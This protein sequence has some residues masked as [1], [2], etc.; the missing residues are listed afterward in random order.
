MRPVQR[1]TT[2]RQRGL[3]ERRDG[4]RHAV[5]LGARHVGLHPAGADR[6]VEHGAVAQVGAAAGQPVGEI[7]V[8]LEVVGPRLPPERGRELP[9]AMPGHDRLGRAACSSSEASPAPAPR[10]PSCHPPRRTAGSSPS[11]RRRIGPSRSLISRFGRGA[12]QVERDHGHQL[13]RR[14]AR[15]AASRRRRSARRGASACLSSMSRSM[16]SSTVPRQTSLCTST[17]RCCPMR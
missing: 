8:A 3:A 12:S 16:R 2:R 10:A 17:L 6:Q 1:P 13:A 11:R 4:D 5:E 7:R 9:L 14:S 15:S